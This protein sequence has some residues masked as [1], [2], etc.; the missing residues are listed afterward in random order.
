MENLSE[1]HNLSNDAALNET[2]N[3]FMKP[4]RYKTRGPYKKRTKGGAEDTAQPKVQVAVPPFSEPSSG[5][6]AQAAPPPLQGIPTKDLLKLPIQVL[7]DW[8]GRLVD[9][10]ARMLPEEQAAICE[11]TAL[12]LDKYAGLMINKYGPEVM[13]ITVWGL[14]FM[15]V[16]QIQEVKREK[17]EAEIKA[18]MDFEKMKAQAEEKAKEVKIGGI[19][20]ADAETEVK[21]VEVVQ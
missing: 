14:W 5:P 20:K 18:K 2:E 11:S 10:K 6:G 4:K 9:E 8:T 19:V 12:V 16:H 17:I 15:R 3:Q 13:C 1:L 7:S 21:S